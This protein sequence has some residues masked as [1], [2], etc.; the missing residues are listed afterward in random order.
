MTSENKKS[1]P[2]SWITVQNEPGW[3]VL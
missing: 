3:L 2:V 1:Q